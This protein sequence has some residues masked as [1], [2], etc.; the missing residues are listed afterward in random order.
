MHCSHWANRGASG[1]HGESAGSS[2]RVPLGG[3]D[4][5]EQAF[6]REGDISF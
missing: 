2:E 3:L 6:V 5:D 1:C 4:G